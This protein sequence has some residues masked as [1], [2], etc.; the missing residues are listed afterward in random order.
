MLQRA[1]SLSHQVYEAVSQQIAAGMLRPG[2]RIVVEHLAEQLGVSPTPVR[3][4]LSRLVRD[5]VVI[6]LPGSKL[7]LIDL[8]PAYISEVFQ[9][10]AALEGLAA[11]LATPR[12]AR[13]ILDSLRQRLA[14]I[15]MSIAAGNIAAYTQSDTELHTF[16]AQTSGNQLLIHSLRSLQL[17]INLIRAFAQRHNSDHLRRSH[18]EHLAILNAF[19]Q[20]DPAIARQ[21][22]ERH[23]RES[24]ARIAQLI[25]L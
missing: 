14:V 16:I 9:V 4:A 23:I 7:Q 15:G 20:R 6:E 19:A 18:D 8:T 22:V 21:S 2:E 10:R 11:E 1:P 25:D 3:E 5:G 24:G 12:I 13:E 17:H